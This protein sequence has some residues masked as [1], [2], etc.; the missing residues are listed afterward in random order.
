[1]HDADLEKKHIKSV[2]LQGRMRRFEGGSTNAALTDHIQP[3]VGKCSHVRPLEDSPFSLLCVMRD[4]SSRL[5]CGRR[6]VVKGESGV[7]YFLRC[8]A[9][10]HHG[11]DTEDILHGMWW[12]R[13][14]FP[15]SSELACGARESCWG[16][17]VEMACMD[18]LCLFVGKV[19]DLKGE[20]IT[21]TLLD[22]TP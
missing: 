5:G 21:V 9:S 10:R 15:M 17:E 11:T 4:A 22:C 13:V 6:R 3:G 8:E 1:M 14:A 19:A 16:A 20:A 18:L 12:W 7:M 2:R